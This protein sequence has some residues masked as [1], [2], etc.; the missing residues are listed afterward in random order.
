MN[1]LCRSIFCICSYLFIIAGLRGQ[2]SDVEKKAPDPGTEKHIAIDEFPK[3]SVINLIDGWGN[4]AVAVNELP[5]GTDLGPLLIGLKD[6]LCQVPHWGL[7]IKG[8][9]RVRYADGNDV[10]LKAGD[11]FYMPPG[12]TGVV[13]DDLKLL[14]FSPAD[15]MKELIK[16]IDAKL[17]KQ[18]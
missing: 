14:D 12:H 18:K 17:Q 8:S 16:H 1:Y 5:K 2:T 15:E 7:I 3:K 10:L 9:L 6:N 4:M 13:L 11:L